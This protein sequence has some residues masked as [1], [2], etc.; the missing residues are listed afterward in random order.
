MHNP[1][2]ELVKVPSVRD[3]VVTFFEDIAL[4]R[5]ENVLVSSS[6]EHA[7]RISL[8]ARKRVSSR[9]IRVSKEYQ[10]RF[11]VSWMVGQ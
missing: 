1:L 7:T 3:Q 9:T 10:T 6:L 11:R 5:K 8:L 4:S 2:T